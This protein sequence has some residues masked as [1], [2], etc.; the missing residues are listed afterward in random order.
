MA[1][2]AALPYTA[3]PSPAPRSSVLL[4]VA[5]P[6]ALPYTV[7]LAPLLD[8]L[9]CSSCRPCRRCR[10]CPGLGCSS[11]ARRPCRR[12]CC[13]PR[14][15]TTAVLPPSLHAFVVHRCLPCRVLF[16]LPRP[17]SLRS[18][19]RRVLHVRPRDSLS[20]A[21]AR[22]PVPVLA[23]PRLVPAAPSL[24][25]S[26]ACASRSPRPGPAIPCPWRWLARRSPPRCQCHVLPRRC[27]S[28]RRP[29]VTLLPPSWRV[30]LFSV[31]CL[32]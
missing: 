24:E 32:E 29:R 27:S 28:L 13:Y 22:S 14:P 20:L 31:R 30:S 26:L 11:A 8:P 15:Q 25:S 3:P 10:Q 16:P 19:V 17:W 18:H 23:L 12:C 9:C 6:A 4:L 21:L 7:P 1:P 2:S 5:P